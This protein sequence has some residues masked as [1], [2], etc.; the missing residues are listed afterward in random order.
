MTEIDFT[1]ECEVVIRTFEDGSPHLAIDEFDTLMVYDN[2]G[3]HD[4]CEGCCQ[5]GDYDYV[6][7]LHE[8]SGGWF[9]MDE[10]SWHNVAKG[11]QA[12]DVMAVGETKDA[13]IDAY[14]ASKSDLI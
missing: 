12:A 1:Y 7:G 2:D 13:C 8:T 10:R 6:G 4:D 11:R 3:S 14:I 5:S 9:L